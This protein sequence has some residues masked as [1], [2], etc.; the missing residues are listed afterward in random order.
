M[1]KLP[2]TWLNSQ[3][4]RHNLHWESWIKSLERSL[5]TSNSASILITK[6]HGTNPMPTSWGDYAK[7]LVPSPTP[8]LLQQR[9]QLQFPHDYN[10][11]LVQTLCNP[12]CSTRSCLID[13]QMWPTHGWSARCAPPKMI[14]TGPASPSEAT[15]LSTL[16][17]L[18]PKLGHSKLSKVSSTVS[19]PVPMHN[20]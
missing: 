8:P 16:V 7:E 1:I 10:V 19:V 18:A 20:S 11:L 2:T 14:P 13:S 17:T 3:A 5:N 12:S 4:L 6:R 15:L 9:K